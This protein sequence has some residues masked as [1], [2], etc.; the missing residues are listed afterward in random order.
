MTRVLYRRYL[1][2]EISEEEWTYRKRQPCVG[3]G[4]ISL[5]PFLDKTWFQRG[6]GGESMMSISIFPMQLPFMTLGETTEQHQHFLSDGAPPFSDLLTFNR[7]LHRTGLV[8]KQLMTFLN[9]PLLLE[10]VH[11]TGVAETEQMRFDALQW[12]KRVE[13]ANGHDTD[14]NSDH[15]VLAVSDLPMVWAFSASSAGNVRVDP[16]SIYPFSPVTRWI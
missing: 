14:G 12:K 10:I 6:G 11:A 15:D 1:R 13:A 2:G 7:F 4:P 9:H 16:F 8:K 3:G 5:R